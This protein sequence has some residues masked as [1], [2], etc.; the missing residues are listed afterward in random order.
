M[1]SEVPF[2]NKTTTIDQLMQASVEE[3]FQRSGAFLAA[4]VWF[5]QRGGQIYIWGPSIPDDIIHD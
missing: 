1:L 4:A 3:C 2:N 5:G